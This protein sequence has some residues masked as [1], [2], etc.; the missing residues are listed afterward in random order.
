M[1]RPGNGECR[2]TRERPRIKDEKFLPCSPAPGV[3]LSPPPHLGQPWDKGEWGEG[4]GK[5][6]R[7]RAFMQAVKL[8]KRAELGGAK[9]SFKD[10][11]LEVRVPKSKEEQNTQ[12]IIE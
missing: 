1:M 2:G 9:A 7:E 10:G 6:R 5:T 3:H 12:I 4:K 8:P 11:V